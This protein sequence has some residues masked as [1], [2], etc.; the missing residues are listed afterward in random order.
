MKSP[1]ELGGSFAAFNRAAHERAAQAVAE[2][3]QADIE[4]GRTPYNER[5]AVID[6]DVVIETEQLIESQAKLKTVLEVVGDV[7][8]LL[9]SQERIGEALA[10]MGE[11]EGL[12]DRLTAG[13]RHVTR[14]VEL[15][16]GYLEH[17]T[18]LYTAG[19]LHVGNESWAATTRLLLDVGEHLNGWIDYANRELTQIS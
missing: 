18:K 9:E 13:V 4:E 16:V 6:H 10:D 2:R 19:R 7:P 3:R 11:L 8:S 5:G 15:V 12:E 17:A 1:D 14:A